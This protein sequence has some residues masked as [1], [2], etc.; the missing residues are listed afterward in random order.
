M[1][2]E[3][4]IEGIK[5]IGKGFGGERKMAVVKMEKRKGKIEVM[6][7]KRRSSKNRG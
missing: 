2:I 5:E 3:E 6:R 1:G 7:K 4:K